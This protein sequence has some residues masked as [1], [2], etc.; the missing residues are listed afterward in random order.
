MN[1]MGVQ[2]LT[3]IYVKNRRAPSTGC[4][5]V[6]TW[7]AVVVAIVVGFLFGLIEKVFKK[8]KKNNRESSVL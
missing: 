1:Y 8:S 5:A 2:T 6:G 4:P 3:K 7:A